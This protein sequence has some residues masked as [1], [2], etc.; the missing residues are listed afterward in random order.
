MANPWIIA[1]GT[2]YPACNK[3][4]LVSTSKDTRESALPLAEM[5]TIIGLKSQISEITANGEDKKD[6]EFL[7]AV[8]SMSMIRNC[9]KPVRISAAQKRSLP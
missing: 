8:G 6:V 4:R 7:V 2:K 1:A 3:Y 9:T 5:V